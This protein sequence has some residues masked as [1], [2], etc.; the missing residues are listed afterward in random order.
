MVLA[1][2][3]VYGALVSN[4]SNYVLF[5]CSRDYNYVEHELV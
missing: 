2:W 4:L 5:N 3:F 1:A